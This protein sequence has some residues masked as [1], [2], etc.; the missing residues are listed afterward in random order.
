MGKSKTT[1][2]RKPAAPTAAERAYAERQ[3]G[4]VAFLASPPAEL[5]AAADA[6]GR[7]L[8]AYGGDT[9]RALADIEAGRHPLQRRRTK[10]ALR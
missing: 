3:E 7:A 9:D 6:V 4:L 5:L 10:T 1:A 8:E 2:A